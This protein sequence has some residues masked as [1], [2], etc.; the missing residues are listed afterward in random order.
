[1]IEYTPFLIALQLF[2]VFLVKSWSR[3]R[4]SNPRPTV[5]DTAAL[6]TELLRQGDNYSVSELFYE[7]NYVSERGTGIEP[8]SN[9]WEGFILPVY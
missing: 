7:D 3:R 9:P 6:P 1:M 5:Y 8:A 2:L 4:E